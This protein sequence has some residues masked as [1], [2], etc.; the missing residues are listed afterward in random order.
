[1]GPV[2]QVLQ[3]FSR[4]V[5]ENLTLGDGEIPFEAVRRAAAISRA[6]AFIRE[7]PEGYA[8]V[9]TDRSRGRG[10]QISVGQRQLLAL[11]RALVRDPDILLLD[12]ATA[13]V[14]S[15]TEAAFKKV[16]QTH[17]N[18]R[19][20]VVLT[21]AHRLSTALQAVR[22]I[23]LEGGRV[24]EEGPPDHLLSHAGR[25]ASLWELGNAGSEWGIPV[26]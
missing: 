12:E 2:P 10:V 21:I 5:L 23:V 11:R 9:L 19:A 22:I 15:A 17:L 13:S 16:L 3:V 20:G 6:D 7:L 1:M 4:S 14:D 8:T 26:R 18:D 25:L 24:V